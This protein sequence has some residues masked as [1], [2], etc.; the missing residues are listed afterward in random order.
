MAVNFEK[1]QNS[2]KDVMKTADLET[3]SLK[4]VLNLVEKDLGLEINSIKKDKDVKKKIKNMVVKLCETAADK[5][6]EDKQKTTVTPEKKNAKKRK[7]VQAPVS[8]AGNKLKKLNRMAR[9]MGK[10]PAIFAKLP[11]NDSDRVKELSKRLKEAGADFSGLLP[12]LNDINKALKETEKRK[13]LEGMDLSNI[14]DSSTRGRRSSRKAIKYSYEESPE[15]EPAQENEEEGSEAS[16]SEQSDSE[17]EVEVELEVQNE[18]AKNKETSKGKVKDT[19]KIATLEAKESKEDESEQNSTPEEKESSNDV[20][21]SDESEDEAKS[22][23]EEIESE[24]EQE[25]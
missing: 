21:E 11:E 20:I 22:Q 17:S 2:V 24:A 10:A 18:D 19:S 16:A 23:R 4:N 12:T 3:I 9:A 15:E 1:I 25:F 5:Q 14:L 6:A 8:S 7:R 13:T